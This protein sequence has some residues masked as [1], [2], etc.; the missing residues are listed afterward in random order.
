M[1]LIAFGNLEAKRKMIVLEDAVNANG[2]NRNVISPQEQYADTNGAIRSCKSKKD[3]Q[4]TVAKRK[5][6]NNDLHYLEN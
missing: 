2:N 1:H 3:K 4:H 6:T 5:R